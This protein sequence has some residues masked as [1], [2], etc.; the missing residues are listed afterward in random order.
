MSRPIAGIANPVMHA[1]IRPLTTYHISG[2]HCF[3]SHLR[4]AELSFSPG[5]A[6]APLPPLLA[7]LSA[8]ASAPPSAAVSAGT[9]ET[10]TMVLGGAAA[11]AWA[12]ASVA[13]L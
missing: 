5:L 6:F 4:A 2:A 8:P 11:T 13:S 12:K 7:F 10:A 9:S 1:P 3:H